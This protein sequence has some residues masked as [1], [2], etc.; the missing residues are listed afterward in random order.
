MHCEMA[1]LH[2]C[3]PQSS[4]VPGSSPE[5][6]M[7]PSASSGPSMPCSKCT[8]H[9]EYGRRR[10]QC[11]VTVGVRAILYTEPYLCLPQAG[12]AYG[13]QAA[14]C[15]TL[16]AKLRYWLAAVVGTSVQV[17]RCSERALQ[18]SKNHHSAPVGQAA[19]WCQ[20]ITPHH[21]FAPLAAMH[22]ADYQCYSPGATT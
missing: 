15:V 8:G 9:S 11:G 3:T 14:E 2:T 21:A 5:Q 7:I 6:A 22:A 13:G 17:R 19:A 12:C 1:V 18:G 16:G 4:A 20:C 10:C